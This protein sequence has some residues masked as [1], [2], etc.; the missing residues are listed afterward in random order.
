MNILLSLFLNFMQFGLFGVGG[1]YAAIP[2]IRA[3]AVQ[4]NG[5]L[6][7]SVFTDLI[8]IAEMTPGPIGINAAT[9]V[10]LRVAGLAGA[11]CATLGCIAPSLA[12]VTLLSWLYSRSRGN[13]SVQTVLRT[14]RAVVVALIAS[15]AIALVK[16]AALDGGRAD[17]FTALIFVAALAL[18]R[19]KKPSPIL[20]IAGCGLARA[21]LHAA[22]V[23]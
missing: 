13:Q 12:L 18:L 23:V 9:F 16:S 15:A 19:W 6:T 11:A 3:I 5:W 20:I 7:E 2:L 1:G 22:G 8:A 21:L 4:Q 14:L 10:G 17:L